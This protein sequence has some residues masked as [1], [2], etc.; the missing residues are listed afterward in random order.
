MTRDEIDRALNNYSAGWTRA[1][2]GAATVSGQVSCTVK[3]DHAWKL[4]CYLSSLPYYGDRITLSEAINCLMRIKPCLD[5]PLVDALESILCPPLGYSLSS[6]ADRVA[7]D[8]RQ[9]Y[10][11]D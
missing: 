10:S 1:A 2:Y 4:Q 11:A 6:L 5:S 9:G 7:E 3:S 8:R